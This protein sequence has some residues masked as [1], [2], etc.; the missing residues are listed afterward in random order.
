[1]N[2]YKKSANQ[3]SRCWHISIYKLLVVLD[4]KSEDNKSQKESSFGSMDVL[5][6]SV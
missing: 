3:A 4:E 1:M 2:A 5:D 6:I